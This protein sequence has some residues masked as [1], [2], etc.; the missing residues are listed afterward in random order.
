M[1]STDVIRIIEEVL[2]TEPGLI[3]ENTLAKDVENWDSMSHLGILIKLDKKFNGKVAEISEI[4]E[5]D[6]IKKI[7]DSLKKYKLISS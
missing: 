2:E 6:S 3:T 7:L 5:A 1:N 4:A